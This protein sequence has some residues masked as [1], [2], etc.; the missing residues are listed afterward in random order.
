MAV[1]EDLLNS[2]AEGNG[3]IATISGAVASGKSELL[4]TASDRAVAGGAVVVDAVASR[5]EHGVRF[6]IVRKII[7]SLPIAPEAT[8][9]ILRLM[10]EA[11]DPASAGVGF[12]VCLSTTLLRLAERQPVVIAVDDV[13]RA[14][15]ASKQFLLHLA[16]RTRRAKVLLLLTTSN[17]TPRD[18]TDFYSELQRQPH[19]TRLRLRLLSR[20]GTSHLISGQLSPHAAN[21]LADEVHTVTGGN[22]MLVQA[23]ID[24]ARAT[25]ESTAASGVPLVRAETYIQGVLD[26][27]HRG[28]SEMLTVARAIAAFGPAAT[29]QTISQLVD[30]PART[31]LQAIED[32][33]HSGLLSDGQFRDP[34][35]RTAILDHAPADVVVRL[36]DRTARLLFDSGASATEVA[37]QVVARGGEADAWTLPVLRKAAE[38]AMVNDDNT[39]A[40]RCLELAYRVCADER[41]RAEINSQ[42]ILATWRTAPAAAGGYLARLTAEAAPDRAVYRNLPMSVAYL[43]WDGQ[44]D[45]AAGIVEEL[46]ETPQTSEPSDLTAIAAARNWLTAFIPHLRPRL[47]GP[48]AAGTAPETE[49]EPEPAGAVAGAS[50]ALPYLHAAATYTAAVTGDSEAEAPVDE[51]IRILQRYHLTDSAVQPLVSVLWALIYADRLDL[52]LSWCERLLDECSSRDTPSWRALLTVVRAEIALR[53]GDLGGAESHA[54]AALDQMSV[55]SWGIAIAHPLAIL[56][57]ACTMMGRY[58]EAGRLLDQAVPP[59]MPHTIAGLHYRQARGRWYLATGRPHAAL[60]TFLAIG[61]S[62]EAFG[63]D[64]PQVVSWH[65]DAAE[66][67]LALGEPKRA[68]ELAES[69]LNRSG[70]GSRRRRAVLLRILGAVETGPR[71]LPMLREAVK[72]LEDHG[73]RLQLAIALGELGRCQQAAGDVNQARMLV[74]KAWHLAKSCGAEPVCEQLIPGYSETEAAPSARATIRQVPESEPLTEAEARVATLAAEGHTNREIAAQLFVTVSTVEQ[75]LTRIYRKLDVRR[76]RDLPAKLSAVDSWAAA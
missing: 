26:C 36:R 17:R 51:A 40:R 57:Q 30:L 54:R 45:R 74:R 1:L 5:A 60:E 56:V 33:G 58:E 31:V 46:T 70:P 47:H 4:V 25:A 12:M 34:A 19:H 14:D 32:L 23:L 21:R 68:K 50:E 8:A 49:P 16:R 55:Q 3:R 67:W 43:A 15:P 6:G 38:Y 65:I 39:F 53:Q 10:E 62:M 76:R 44:V 7:A 20:S 66:A 2:T 71:R 52:A 35:A 59:A 41:E 72:I 69:Q 24:D 27:L 29:P 42:L 37:Q 9:M 64:N 48:D 61:K 75:H 63:T 28:D 73:S 11:G 22:P 13:H 18:Q